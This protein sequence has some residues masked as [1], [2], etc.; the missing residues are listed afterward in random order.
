[1]NQSSFIF[2]QILYV[3]LFIVIT[4]YQRKDLILYYRDA[5]KAVGI[6]LIVPLCFLIYATIF[7]ASLDDSSIFSFIWFP[8][9]PILQALSYF[10]SL[11]LYKPIRPFV[12]TFLI[13]EIVAFIYVYI[14]YSMAVTGDWI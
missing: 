4:F 14:V 5:L 7:P 11:Y 1:M 9:I 3:V 12:A 2:A 6:T 8:G 10:L 13:G